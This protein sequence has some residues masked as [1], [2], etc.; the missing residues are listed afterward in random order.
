MTLVT[1]EALLIEDHGKV[2]EVLSEE[3]ERVMELT[4]D[5]LRHHRGHLVAVLQDRVYSFKRLSDCFDLAYVYNKKANADKCT[6]RIC[7]LILKNQ[8]TGLLV[9]KIL[10]FSKIVVKDFDQKYLEN[11][12]VFEGYMI[13]GDGQV[14]M[15]LNLEQVL[16]YD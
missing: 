15:V 9:E 16:S 11:I 1:K 8:R 4:T 10:D 6:Q 7:G 2:F 12:P 3:I 14:V 13:R 5:Q